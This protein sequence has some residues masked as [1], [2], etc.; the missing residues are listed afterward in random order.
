MTP[1]ADRAR[2]AFLGLA[3]GD[4]FGRTLEFIHGPRVRTAPV[5]V[6]PGTFHWTDDTHMSLYLAEA[7]LA[8]GPAPVDA[9]RF[10]EAVGTQFTRWLDDPLMPRRGR[11][12]RAS[13]ARAGGRGAGTGARA[14]CARDRGAGP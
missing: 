14:G 2:A 11:A 3:V 10:G 7:V 8:H 13:R 1:F 9:D 6:T 12:G 5:D 4:A